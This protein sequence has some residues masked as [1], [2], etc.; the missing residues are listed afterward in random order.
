MIIILTDKSAIMQVFGGLMRQP[1][2]LSDKMAYN[3]TPDDF[4]TTFERYIFTAIYNLYQNGALNISVVD[5]DN[6]LIKHEAAYATFEKARGVEYLQDCY[7]MAQLE[8]FQYYYNRVKKFNALKDLKKLGYNI[9]GIYCDDLV[10]PNAEKINNKFETLSLN[11]I[12]DLIK[13]ELNKIENRYTIQEGIVEAPAAF[14]IEKLID[15][16]GVN[17][18]IGPNL[19]GHI[20]NTLTRGARRGKLYLRSASSGSGK[21]RL[22]VGDACYLAYPIRFDSE[23]NK[24]V[25]CGG[26]EKVLF[27]V[28]EQSVDEIQTMILAYLTN[29]NEEII[30]F[31]KYDKEQ[32]ERL[33]IAAEI[34]HHFEKNFFIVK[35]SDPNISSLKAIVRKYYIQYDIENLFYDY[36][37]SSP[38]LLNEFRDLKIREDVAL[39]L[40]STALKDL[41]TE[42]NL[43]VMS[44]TQLNSEG[45]DTNKPIKNESA[46]RGS[47]AIID[48]IDIGCVAQAVTDDD[49]KILSG[50][51]QN[52][53]FTPNLVIDLYKSRRN[54]Y[55]NV[56]IWCLADLG[57]CRKIDL[58]LTDSRFNEVDG[59]EPVI[60]MFTEE[61]YEW[62]NLIYKFNK[63]EIEQSAPEPALDDWDRL[64]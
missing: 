42:L 31:G 2:F 61:S 29:I 5:I 19:Q 11:G 53:G 3:L 63:V 13:G 35:I 24:W 10:N 20:F 33:A 4:D 12:F 58:F 60:F 43:F 16:L 62:L 26:T 8:N 21:T 18:D 25:H 46:I 38:A 59:F 55:K 41:A 22:S 1:D 45:D 50:V 17:P 44:S 14:N 30:L 6:Y 56:K 52:Y 37:F 40:L 39:R 7:D 27:V 47:R 57:T 9:D 36:I 54:R 64:I 34:M 15:T 49:L 23:Q 28:T 51:I 48:K 32:K